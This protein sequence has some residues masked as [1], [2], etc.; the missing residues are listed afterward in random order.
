VHNPKQSLQRISTDDG[1][2]IDFN[3][4]R[5][6]ADSSIRFNFESFSNR[7]DWHHAKQDLQRIS[8]DD[9]IMIDF[10]PE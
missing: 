4:E 9:G 5:E 8:T 6:N 2:M 3:P 10:N 7:S 1:M